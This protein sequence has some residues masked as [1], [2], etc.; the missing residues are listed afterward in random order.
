M[1]NTKKTQQEFSKKCEAI[2]IDLGAEKTL[3]NERYSFAIKTSIGRLFLR[4][5][6]DNSSMFTVYG[7]FLDEPTKAKSIF[8]HWKRNL[9]TTNCLPEALA[10]IKY[11][12]SDTIYQVQLSK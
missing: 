11:F 10:E 2:L 8:G 1:R 5:D 9:H 12:F 6:D 7:N 4:I 3:D